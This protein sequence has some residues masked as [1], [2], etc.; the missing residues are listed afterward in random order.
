LTNPLPFTVIA[1]APA[2]TDAGAMLASTGRGFSKVRVLAPDAVASAELTARTVTVLE[3]GT[4]FGAV[5]KPEAL[6][7]PVAV[8]PPATPFTCHVT[9]VFEDPV[10]T[11]LSD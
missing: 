10:M 7:V 9:A 6:I 3:F 8:F 1:N 4:M 11:A 2:G 5:Y